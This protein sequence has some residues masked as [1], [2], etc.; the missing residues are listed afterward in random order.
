[1]QRLS[2]HLGTEPPSTLL[3]P[4]SYPYQTSGKHP[5]HLYPSPGPTG[6][7]AMTTAE[8]FCLGEKEVRE[9]G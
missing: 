7:P 5:G 2:V 3:V 9:E 4:Q 1:M 8:F 6:G